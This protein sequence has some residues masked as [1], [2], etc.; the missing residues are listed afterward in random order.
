ML[1]NNYKQP[2]SSIGRCDC[3]CPKRPERDFFQTLT[4]ENCVPI[5]GSLGVANIIFDVEAASLPVVLAGSIEKF[6]GTEIF[7]IFERNGVSSAPVPIQDSLTFIY[8]DVT[9][10]T[11]NSREDYTGSFKFQATYTVEV[12]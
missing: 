7:A 3:K 4:I 8:D 6:T 2:M 5:A 9:Q 11:I 1:N 12:E 10:V